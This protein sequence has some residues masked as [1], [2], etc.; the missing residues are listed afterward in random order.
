MESFHR[1]PVGLRFKMV[2]F[3][4]ISGTI[5]DRKLSPPVTQ[6]CENQLRFLYLSF[7]CNSELEAIEEHR[8]WNKQAL[9]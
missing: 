4:F 6:L 1:F 9:R 7:A 5:C 8:S 3:A 2:D